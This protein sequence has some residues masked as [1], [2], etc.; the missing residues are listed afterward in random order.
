[1]IC[2]TNS[3]AGKNTIINQFVLFE[4]NSRDESTNFCQNFFFQMTN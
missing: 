3:L 4:N 2:I 1:M